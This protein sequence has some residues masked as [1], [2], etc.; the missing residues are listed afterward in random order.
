MDRLFHR[1]AGPGDALLV[2]GKL[3]AAR[4]DRLPKPLDREVR[5][6][7]GDRL[8]PTPY[9][10]EFTCHSGHGIARRPGT[11]RAMTQMPPDLHEWITF[12]D[13]DG[14]T[15]LFDITF[16]TSNYECIYGSGCPGVFTVLAPVYEPG[17]CTYGA[18]FVDKADRQ[19]I[20]R[21]IEALEPGEWEFADR[22]E[23]MG[24]AVFKND[25]GEWVTH[26]VDDA[27][28][29]LNRPGFEHGAGCALH[30]AAL[31]RGERPIDW[32]PDVCWQVPLR[33]DE[34]T[35]D[36][37]HTTYILREWKRR[38][39]GEGGVEFAWWCTDDPLAFSSDRPVWKSHR[40]EIVELVGEGPYQQLVDHLL[41]R[42]VE[43]NPPVFL[44]HPEVRRRD[45]GE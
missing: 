20:R 45:G 26:T 28:I 6:V 42:A 12:A 30:Q 25:D 39:W 15:W 35:D 17:C 36:N 29:M 5:E 23:E 44:P 11:V 7:L 2:D 33:F 4:V 16:L 37:G 27:C 31:R 10:V 13:D 1:P 22:A 34:W 3:P 38:D 9:L 21:K 19:S 41:A 32:K 14:D 40:E 18:H 24:G 43:P 8:Q